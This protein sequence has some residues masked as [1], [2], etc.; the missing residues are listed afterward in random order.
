MNDGRPHSALKV[1]FTSYSLFRR[2]VCLSADGVL[3]GFPIL[4]LYRDEALRY[5]ED[6]ECPCGY[7]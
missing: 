4:L 5:G 1:D 2:V 3:D 6:G 7:A